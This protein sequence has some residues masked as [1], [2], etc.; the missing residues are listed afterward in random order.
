MPVAPPQAIDMQGDL[1]VINK[2]LEKL[3][4]QIIHLMQNPQIREKMA[5]ANLKIAESKA[6]WKKNK[7]IF[8]NALKTLSG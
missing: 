1:S 7:Q 3:A 4:K 8:F 5:N 6:D 2:S